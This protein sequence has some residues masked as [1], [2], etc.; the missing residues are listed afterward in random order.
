MSVSSSFLAHMKRLMRSALDPVPRSLSVRSLA[1]LVTMLVGGI[2]ITVHEYLESGKDSRRTSTART[3]PVG[4]ARTQRIGESGPAPASRAFEVGP[5]SA[6]SPT[7]CDR[8]VESET[9]A[10]SEPGLWIPDA[11]SSGS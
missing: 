5:V 11:R 2:A 7:T 3:S 10:T 8:P 6:P 4:S 1:I 9:S